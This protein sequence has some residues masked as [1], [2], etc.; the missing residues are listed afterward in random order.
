MPL[1]RLSRKLNLLSHYHEVF[2]T[3]FCG[4]TIFFNAL[5]EMCDILFKPMVG[6]CTSFLTFCRNFQ[7]ILL[8]KFE[9]TTKVFQ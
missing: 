2:T 5:Y 7:I 4:A 8:L 6:T 9:N 3:I 1:S